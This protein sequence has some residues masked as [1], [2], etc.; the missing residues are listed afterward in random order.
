M[1]SWILVSDHLN[2]SDPN[3][4]DSPENIK[5]NLKKVSVLFRAGSGLR[6]KLQKKAFF[7]VENL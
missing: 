2:L 4:H 1:P 3:I 5:E 6:K 7:Q